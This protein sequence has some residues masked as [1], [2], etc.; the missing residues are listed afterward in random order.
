MHSRREVLRVQMPG[1]DGAAAAAAACCL[2][3]LHSRLPSPP[4]PSL[5]SCQTT[6]ARRHWHTDASAVAACEAKPV[7][8]KPTLLGSPIGR[9]SI[10][11][12]QARAAPHVV[13]AHPRRLPRHIVGTQPSVAAPSR[14]TQSL[15]STAPSARRP[16]AL[17]PRSAR[18][19]P[20]RLLAADVTTAG[21]CPP[22]MARVGPRRLAW[23]CDGDWVCQLA[24]FSRAITI[25]AVSCRLAANRRRPWRPPN[26]RQRCVADR[27]PDAAETHPRRSKGAAPLCLERTVEALETGCSP[28]GRSLPL[29]TRTPHASTRQRC[30]IL[31]CTYCVPTVYLPTALPISAS[32]SAHTRFAAHHN[33]TTK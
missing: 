15:H 12:R 9:T 33:G 31:P 18:R 25:G 2:L 11:N 17:C 10:G 30:R 6:A 22:R 27:E 28:P 26:P 1:G 4:S 5:H 20:A 14:C 19:P 8:K 3:P 13:T 32:V 21:Q 24:S 23:E 16:S 7:L 29:V